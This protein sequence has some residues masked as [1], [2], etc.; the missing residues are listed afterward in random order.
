MRMIIDAMQ[1]G[2]KATIGRAR[3]PPMQRPAK[4]ATKQEVIYKW[5]NTM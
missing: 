2:R 3:R 5:Y 4:G 1:S